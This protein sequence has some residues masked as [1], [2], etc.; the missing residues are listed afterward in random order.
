[1][2]KVFS[3]MPGSQYSWLLGY[4][5]KLGHRKNL[6]DKATKEKGTQKAAELLQPMA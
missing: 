1:M 5:L 2:S 3:I 4:F 6:L